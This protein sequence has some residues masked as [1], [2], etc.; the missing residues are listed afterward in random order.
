MPTS[1]ELSIGETWHP[2][3]LTVH[4]YGREG[5]F[6]SGV[7]LLLSIGESNGFVD[8]RGSEATIKAISPGKLELKIAS[9]CGG[10]P[11]GKL[12]LKILAE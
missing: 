11:S 5:A 1:I 9:Y 3:Q 6:I 12:K 2:E 7:P 8:T 4:A 10:S